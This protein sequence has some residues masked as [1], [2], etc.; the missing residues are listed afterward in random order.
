MKIEVRKD[1]YALCNGK[2]KTAKKI[3]MLIQCCDAF[4]DE[5]INNSLVTVQDWK[6]ESLLKLIFADQDGDPNYIYIEYCPFCGE[7]IEISYIENNIVREYTEL[8]TQKTELEEKRKLTD[9]KIED[10]E[11]RDKIFDVA[12]KMRLISSDRSELR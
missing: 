3:R 12:S 5:L 8:E 10:T 2:A 11:L 7:K 9:S 4:Y 1:T 6:N